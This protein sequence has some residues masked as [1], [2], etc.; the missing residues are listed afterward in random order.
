[1]SGQYELTVEIGPFQE[2][3]GRKDATGLRIVSNGDINSM[4]VKVHIEKTIVGFPADARIAIWN[5]SKRTRNA[6][7][8][9]GLKVVV[10][11]GYQSGKK[12]QLY[13]GSLLT[14]PTARS[15]AD[16]V[17]TLICRPAYSNMVQK[18]VSK[19]WEKDVP[20][21]RVLQDIV[22]EIPNVIYDPENKNITGKIGYSGFSYMG[23]I[24]GALNKLGDQFGFSWNITN[25]VFTA[26]MDDSTAAAGISLSSMTGLRKVSPRLSGIMSTQ[27]GV[28]ISCLYRQ[29][30]TPGQLVRIEPS[31]SYELAGDYKIHT[32]EY[33]LSPKDEEWGI[34]IVTF[35]QIPQL[36]GVG[37]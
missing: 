26:I 25:G 11:A 34:N 17:T 29:G 12:E 20:L 10:W 5:L 36:Q 30:M 2:W 21:S 27:I 37:Q 28:D 32:I 18:V 35:I 14:A 16:W 9:P 23:T 6:L 1:M 3:V 22:A 19:T 24:N 15:G 8:T 7:R 31:V 13:T 33:D 4:K